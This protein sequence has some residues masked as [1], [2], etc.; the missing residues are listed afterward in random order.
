MAMAE[1]PLV[2]RMISATF[3]SGIDGLRPRPGRTPPS[4]Q[5]LKAN[6]CRQV[7]VTVAGETP[8]SAAILVFASPAP[9]IKAPEH[10][11]PSDALPSHIDSF[12]S[13]PSRCSPVTCNG[14]LGGRIHGLTKY[15]QLF[16]RHYTRD[17]IHPLASRRFGGVAVPLLGLPRARR[18][19]LRMSA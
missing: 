5:T 1:Q 12:S 7:V 16:T 17:S 10:A 13:I 11:E 19:C 4:L 15:P 14:G 8:N 9:A 2:K 6:R 18:R 3:T